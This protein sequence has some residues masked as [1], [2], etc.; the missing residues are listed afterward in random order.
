MKN[1]G[2]ILMYMAA[3]AFWAIIII[4]VLVEGSLRI[5]RALS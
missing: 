2:G 5:I 4:Y 1:L 3:V